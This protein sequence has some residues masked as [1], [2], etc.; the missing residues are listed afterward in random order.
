[1]WQMRFMVRHFGTILM[2]NEV[3]E[4]KKKLIK[5]LFSMSGTFLL[6]PYIAFNYL[7][8]NRNREV[9]SNRIATGL[10]LQV[11]FTV[12]NY[13]WSRQYRQFDIEMQKKYLN[14]LPEYYIQNFETEYLPWLLQ[15][16]SS[17]AVYQTST[18]I[19]LMLNQG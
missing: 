17:A 6:M 7:T 10:I 13:R 12:L 9:K 4:Y 8:L 18:S 14:D 15:Q 19:P 2:P 5:A 1:M 11:I 16:R 3:Q